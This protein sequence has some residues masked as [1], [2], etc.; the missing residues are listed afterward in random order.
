MTLVRKFRSSRTEFRRA[1]ALVALSAVLALGLGRLTAVY[2]SF[3]AHSRIGAAANAGQ[4][5]FLD[6]DT[7]EW[8]QP[9]SIFSFQAPDKA[10][11][12]ARLTSDTERTFDTDGFHYNRPPPVL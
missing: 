2:S 11:L 3:S 12:T 4:R 8:C 7:S 5:W 1:F 9:A 6:H 10:L